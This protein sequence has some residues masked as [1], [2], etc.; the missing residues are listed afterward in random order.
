MKK[1]AVFYISVHH[2]NTE[3]LLQGVKKNLDID[4]FDIQQNTNVD[5]SKYDII[6]IATGIYAFKPHKLIYKFLQEN[7]NLP[8]KAISICT[9][10]SGSQKFLDKL[11]NVLKENGLDVL[12]S[13]T[14]KGYDT[15]GPFKLVGGIAKGHPTAQDIENATKF[16][17][18]I[19]SK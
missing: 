12:D 4:I 6:G 2:K 8:K 10:G 3:K 11:S 9:S 13:F 7:K 19:I 15:F 16:I 14:C 17:Q 18:D 1:L 5:M